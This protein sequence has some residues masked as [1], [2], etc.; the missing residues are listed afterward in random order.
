[1]KGQKS[2]RDWIGRSKLFVGQQRPAFA[3]FDIV[4]SGVS[5][6]ASADVKSN[7]SAEERFGNAEEAS[8]VALF[9]NAVDDGFFGRVSSCETCLPCGASSCKR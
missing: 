1:V 4:K 8:A 9:C 3:I 7:L 2:N 6:E 5:E